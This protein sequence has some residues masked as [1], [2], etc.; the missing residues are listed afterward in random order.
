MSCP[1]W[2]K[3]AN[4]INTYSGSACTHNAVT[5]CL[6]LLAWARVGERFPAAGWAQ[7]SLTQE[8]EARNDMHA[9]RWPL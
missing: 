9:K 6:R 1:A 2:N 5:Q 3:T 4:D 8:A 7:F